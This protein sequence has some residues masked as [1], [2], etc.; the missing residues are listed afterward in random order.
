MIDDS[1]NILYTEYAALKRRRDAWEETVKKAK[2]RHKVELADLAGDMFDQQDEGR[3]NELRDKFAEGMPVDN[4]VLTIAFYSSSKW[5][6]E[7]SGLELLLDLH[8]KGIALDKLVK[9][10]AWDKSK[11]DD[12][13]GAWVLM[14]KP[15]LGATEVQGEIMQVTVKKIVEPAIS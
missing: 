2:D 1:K 8:G 4:D 9:T 12:V 14:G 3:Y 11:I 5:V 13:L 10:V 7:G 6:I 15:L